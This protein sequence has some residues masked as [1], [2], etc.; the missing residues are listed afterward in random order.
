[1]VH[2]IRHMAARARAFFASPKGKSGFTLTELAVVVAFV[3]LIIG[4]VAAVQNVR[5]S[6]ER[7]RVTKEGGE[8]VRL[9]TDFKERY[10]YWPGDYP[11]DDVPLAMRGNGDGIYSS[12][13]PEGLYAWQQLKHV[14]MYT[15]QLTRSYPSLIGVAE[16][17]AENEARPGRNVPAS[18]VA[19]G[20]WVPLEFFVS[21]ASDT[22]FT[23]VLRLGLPAEDSLLM[24]NGIITPSQLYQIDVKADDGY[25]ESGRI[26]GTSTRTPSG[27]VTSVVTGSGAGGL[28]GQCSAACGCVSGTSTSTSSGSTSTSSGVDQPCTGAGDCGT[29]CCVNQICRDSSVCTGSSSGASS[30]TSSSG[31]NNPCVGASDCAT[32]CCVNQFCAESSVC[33]ASSSSS[34]S[35]CN[36]PQECVS[37]CCVN[38]ICSTQN[39]CGASSSSGSGTPCTYAADCPSGCCVNQFCAAASVC[40]GSSSGASSGAS[41]SGVYECKPACTDCENCVNGACVDNGDPDC[42]PSVCEPACNDCQHCVDGVCVDNGDPACNPSECTPACG[43]C[44]LCV[45]SQCVSDNNPN[46]NA[47]PC[48]QNSDCKGSLGCVACVAGECEPLPENRCPISGGGFGCCNGGAC[49]PSGGSSCQVSSTSSGASSGASGASSSGTTGECDGLNYDYTAEQCCPDGSIKDILDTCSSS[50][51]G[52]TSTSTSSSGGTGSTSTSSSSSSSSGGTSSGGPSCQDPCPGGITGQPAV[53]QIPC[54]P[55]VG[56]GIMCC[57]QCKTTCIIGD[58]PP[59]MLP[60]EGQGCLPPGTHY[61]NDPLECT[62]QATCPPRPDPSCNRPCPRDITVCGDPAQICE[63]VPI[64]GEGTTAQQ[65]CELE[66]IGSPQN[67]YTQNCTLNCWQEPDPTCASSSSGGAAPCHCGG[68]PYTCPAQQQAEGWGPLTCCG[69]QKLI[70]TDK[71]GNRMND[72]WDCCSSGGGDDPYNTANEECCNGNPVP[73]GQCSSSGLP[74][75]CYTY[76]SKDEKDNYDNGYYNYWNPPPL[77]KSLGYAKCKSM[78]PAPKAPFTH[79]TMWYYSPAPIDMTYESCRYVNTAACTEAQYDQDF[80][81]GGGSGGTPMVITLYKD[82]QNNYVTKMKAGQPYCTYSLNGL[83]HNYTI[84]DNKCL[85]CNVSAFGKSQADIMQACMDATGNYAFAGYE[86]G[87]DWW[88]TAQCLDTNGKFAPNCSL[89]S[90]SGP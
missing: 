49:R 24:E 70:G 28:A 86:T 65:L 66:N 29:S 14:G 37:E 57:F 63:M 71:N 2:P 89:P 11:G 67:C 19:G 59:C 54:P 62:N 34:G 33:G 4:A 40:T 15:P 31:V 23:N 25:P 58:L 41:S 78:E 90:S 26:L 6:G 64:Y 1:M 68:V 32:S 83:H 22:L 55:N 44:Q 16:A 12:N 45:D 9:F 53:G 35:D 38:N 5:E 43:E 69:N 84:P 88:T 39:I 60:N 85:L 36:A 75:S 48:T 47:N 73:I 17:S 10:N 50:S 13:P 20:G 18:S 52:S 56:P 21:V 8:Y 82:M 80:G 76:A 3:A 77:N 51:G 87:Y 81:V 27:G 79:V 7:A 30:G 74:E 46:C 61:L 72:G 42:E